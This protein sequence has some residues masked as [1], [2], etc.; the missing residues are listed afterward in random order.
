MLTIKAY[1][2][3]K[4]CLFSFLVSILGVALWQNAEQVHTIEA[5]NQARKLDNQARKFESL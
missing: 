4:V 1:V 3:V 5:D 2:G